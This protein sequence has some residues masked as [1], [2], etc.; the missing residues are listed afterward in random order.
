[1]LRVSLCVLH[2]CVGGGS[3]RLPQLLLIALSSLASLPSSFVG[4]SCVWLE[5]EGTQRGVI[6]RAGGCV[7]PRSEAAN[8]CVPDQKLQTLT[9]PFLLVRRT[10]RKCRALFSWSCV[11]VCV[12]VQ[13]CVCVCVCVCAARCGR[14]RAL[15]FWSTALVVVVVRASCLDACVAPCDACVAPSHPRAFPSCARPRLRACT[16]LC[17]RAPEQAQ[18]AG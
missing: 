10:S 5:E 1:M 11:C 15:C 4:G 7:C 13:V 2:V 12:C 3:D 16:C 18:G 14:G 6:G 9:S 8:A 17:V